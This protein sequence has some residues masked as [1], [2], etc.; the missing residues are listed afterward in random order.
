[1]A[2]QPLQDVVELRPVYHGRVK[3]NVRGHI[4]VCFLALYLAAL[5]RQQLA[6]ARLEIPWDEVIR[7][8]ATVRAV[9]VNSLAS[10][11]R[12]ARRWR[13]R[14]QDLRRRRDQG[15][16]ARTAGVGG[17]HRDRRRAVPKSRVAL[18]THRDYS[19][20]ASELSNLGLRGTGSPAG[21]L[22]CV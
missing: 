20:F 22:S 18:P 21:T 5:L 19:E 1:M 6:A 13:P 15:A 16:A 10:T 12:C 11:T 4:F 9:T 17:E 3:D 8:L 2:V 7:D 14:R